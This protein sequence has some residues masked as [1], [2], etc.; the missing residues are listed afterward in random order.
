MSSLNGTTFTIGNLKQFTEEPAEGYRVARVIA[1][2]GIVEK[3]K[4]ESQGCIIPVIGENA[5]QRIMLNEIGRNWFAAKVQEV[6]DRLIR[7]LVATGRESAL[8]HETISV[9]MLIQVMRAENESSRFSKESIK[10]W[11]DASLKP[12]ILARLSEKMAG[13]PE[14]TLEKLAAQY[15]D[16]FQI[17]A[18]RSPTM[19]SAIRAQLLRAMELLPEDHDSITATTILE[20]LA[21]VTE[22]SV[23]LSAL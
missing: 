17:L 12:L 19:S 18:G 11:F 9:E 10:E 6:Q 20:K 1:K 21:T 7:K 8:S 5:L 15:L 23:V 13:T 14:S 4:I 2:G 22:A 16:S 3:R